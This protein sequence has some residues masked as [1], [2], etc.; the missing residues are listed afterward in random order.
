MPRSRRA[1]Y[2]TF[3]A[4]ILPVLLAFAALGVD[5]FWQETC[6]M[7]V[8]N[9]V[10]AVAHGGAMGL[11]GTVAGF[12]VA[13]NLAGDVGAR[14]YIAGSPLQVLPGAGIDSY[15]V[16]LG[17]WQNNTFTPDISN[18]RL[19]T[20]VQ[21]I[22]QRRGLPTF[23]ARPAFGVDALAVQAEAIAVAGGPGVVG[24]VLPL[25]IPSCELTMAP[26]ICDVSLTLNPDT[27]YSGAWAIAGDGRPSAQSVRNAIHTCV[28]GD[29]SQALS[30]N[31][32]AIN[33]GSQALA[34]AVDVSTEAW[35]TG[36]WGPLPTQ[37]ARS[38]VTHY[39]HVLTSLIYVFNDPTN[40]VA[41]SYNGTGPAIR[42]RAWAAAG[43]S[44]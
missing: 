33:S 35:N 38:G 2:A 1:N 25:A 11:D 23:F 6:R 8:Q 29:I 12:T 17:R 40:C 15:T 44:A 32:G 22:Y 7:E 3:T 34:E 39:G 4:L 28:P 19:V 42:S 10:D 13:R 37:S 14:N 9:G 18:P 20:A 30:L 16:N 26:D 43:S 21:A 27:N 24:C 31:N 36:E 41:T 5:R